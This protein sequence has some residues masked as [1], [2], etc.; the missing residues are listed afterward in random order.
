MQA[1]RGGHREETEEKEEEK[2]HRR[3]SLGHDGGGVWKKGVGKVKSP[4]LGACEQVED[5]QPW[6][7]GVSFPRTVL[8]LSPP[9]LQVPGGLGSE[10]RGPGSLTRGRGRQERRG[11]RAGQER[12]FWPRAGLLSGGRAPESGAAAFP[13]RSAEA[14][15]PSSPPHPPPPPRPPPLLKINRA[16]ACKSSG[17]QR[18]GPEEPRVRLRLSGPAPLSAPRRAQ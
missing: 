11:L 6:Q 17:N 7:A 1:S 12:S 2:K 16:V 10:R 3:G 4:H 14:P 8:P 15:G 13:T 5:P 18:S 9:S